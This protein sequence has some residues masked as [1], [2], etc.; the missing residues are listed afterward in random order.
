MGDEKF[1]RR[2]LVP[3]DG[4]VSS[5]MAEETAA[6][7][8]K[9]T[10]AT[11]TALHVTQELRIGYRLPL[12]LQDE[13]LGSIEQHAKKVAN[14]ARALFNEEGVPV[15]TEILSG[16]DPSEI[17][18]DLSEKDYDLIV[19]G[20]RGENETETFALGSVT[21]KVVRHVT[22]P[23]LITKRVCALANLLVGVD[24]SAHS[25]NA[26]S[27]AARL[28]DEMDA[29]ITLLNVQE[30][31]LVDLSRRTA[32]EFGEK[33]LS[34]ALDIIA[35]RGVEVHKRLEFGVPSNRIVEVAEEGNHDLIVL[36]SRGLGAVKRFLLGSVSDDVSHKAKCSVLIVPAKLKYSVS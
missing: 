28:A 21:K 9:K 19:M 5:L 30:R 1:L 22:C 17:I 3:V 34:N 16:G 18:L 26:L 2:V 20:G 10:G 27:Y 15:N 14:D 31:R 29:K 4:S 6:V 32:E 8:A 35:K 36:G 25:S 23:T 11:I 7:V 13:L 12:K 33:I 24:G